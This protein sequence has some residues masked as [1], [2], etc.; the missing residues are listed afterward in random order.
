MSLCDS[1]YTK[2]VVY[3]R[4][5]EAVCKEGDVVMYGVDGVVLPERRYGNIL[6]VGHL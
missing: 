1:I 5:S 4:I 3:V 6:L 2:V